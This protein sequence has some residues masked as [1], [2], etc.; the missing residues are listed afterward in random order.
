MNRKINAGRIAIIFVMKTASMTGAS[1]C[2]RSNQLYIGVLPYTLNSPDRF[3][4]PTGGADDDNLIPAP[5]LHPLGSHTVDA[6]H[7]SV[8]FPTIVRWSKSGTHI[9]STIPVGREGCG[10]AIFKLRPSAKTLRPLCHLDCPGDTRG[11]VWL[12]FEQDT[13]ITYTAN[14]IQLYSLKESSTP[15][16]P[17]FCWNV[18]RL[19][20]LGDDHSAITSI[21][22]DPTGC[23]LCIV[24]ERSDVAFVNLSS[25]DASSETTA[26]HSAQ[27]VEHLLTIANVTSSTECAKFAQFNTSIGPNDSATDSTAVYVSHGVHPTY[28]QGKTWHSMAF[29][30]LDLIELTDP[31][32]LNEELRSSFL[33]AAT[34]MDIID[35]GA[36]VLVQSD[37][38]E[39]KSPV[40]LTLEAESGM[41]VYAPGV[42]G[43]KL[44]YVTN[45]FP[46]NQL[47]RVCGYVKTHTGDKAGPVLVPGFTEPAPRADK[48]VIAA[49]DGT[50]GAI[51]VCS[52]PV[53]S[54][55]GPVSQGSQGSQSPAQI[56]TVATPEVSRTAL[57]EAMKL[58]A[59]GPVEAEEDG[60]EEMEQAEPDHV[61][62]DEGQG[63]TIA[64]SGQERPLAMPEPSAPPTLPPTSRP[65]QGP[66]MPPAPARQTQD[67]GPGFDVRTRRP[68][69]EGEA[70][71]ARPI[72]VEAAGRVR[73][74]S[75]A[76]LS[77]SV[78]QIACQFDTAAP[79]PLSDPLAISQSHSS[80]D[81]QVAWDLPVP[82]IVT[83]LTG[84]SEIIIAGTASGL[85]FGLNTLT[86][87]PAGLPLALGDPVRAAQAGVVDGQSRV[88][89]ITDLGDVFVVD[90]GLR[91]VAK[92]SV[93]EL[94]A[95]GATVISVGLVGSNPLV[96]TTSGL[97]T[98]TPT[99]A[100]DSW[101]VLMSAPLASLGA[102]GLMS[103]LPGNSI[104]QGLLAP[105]A[106]C[107]FTANLQ[108]GA[109][110]DCLCHLGLHVARVCDLIDTTGRG[111][112]EAMDVVRGL[113]RGDQ[114]WV[115][116]LG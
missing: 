36:T 2:A 42:C 58:L 111:R 15:I 116:R 25:V 39:M 52:I 35:C 77:D 22:I 16:A 72:R 84:T 50:A 107:D 61:Q 89:L 73:F 97:Y 47:R 71:S 17:V 45:L 3:R 96:R 55:L 5:M 34:V 115:M 38:V 93:A 99:L 21:T 7:A 37:G 18:D 60:D 43:N 19:C 27:R 44:I 11:L 69:F 8:S 101:S 103:L 49:I 12:P 70:A 109:R 98:V 75:V 20:N 74:V 83:A 14:T 113:T 54:L 48:L 10:V 56:T 23:M 51:A 62:P 102:R 108:E 100:R 90:G 94:L 106:E 33:T 85:V 9:A 59:G 53:A 105:H 86:G 104:I 63:Q 46:F 87:T 88:V 81:N 13:I 28:E 30:D 92:A 78:C 82:D 67:V 112:V 41:S 1:D 64:Q 114:A 26:K 40:L 80:R 95:D 65:A 24:F 76:P 110:R 29:I 68:V 4:T 91:V 31:P 66:R 79:T 6:T 32:H 57:V